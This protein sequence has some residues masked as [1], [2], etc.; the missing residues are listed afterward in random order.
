[1]PTL[2]IDA[3]NSRI[4]WV[5]A[6][7]DEWQAP[8]AIDNAHIQDMPRLIA[9]LP[10]PSRIVIASVAGDTIAQNLRMICAHWRVR[11]EF[12]TARPSQCGVINRYD[13]PQRL[14]CDRWA[15][16]IAAWHL[17]RRAC[18]VVN[19]G[20]ATTVD[21]LSASGEFIGGLILPGTGL[22]LHSLSNGTALLGQGQGDWQAFPRNTADAME[23]GIIQA[24]VGAIER[25]YVRLGLPHARCILGGGNAGRVIE[26][27]SMPVE[28]IG[29]LVLRGLHIIAD[30]GGTT[31]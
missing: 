12:I 19:C 11:P 4:K 10:K 7:G 30:E 15:A 31:A 27:L 9:Q 2:L 13:E 18:L 1:M 16:L 21:A 25:Q 23:S 6:E 20:T 22:M 24:T 3:G 5:L 28:H 14:G 26:H 8:G 29:N 17:E